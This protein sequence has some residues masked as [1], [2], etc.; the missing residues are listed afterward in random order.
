MTSQ[1][2]LG[3][4]GLIVLAGLGPLAAGSAHAQDDSYLYGGISAGASR[5]KIDQDRIAASLLGAGLA[6]TG[7]QRDERGNAFRVFGGYQFN[8]NIALE[9]GYFDLGKFGFNASTAPAGTLNGQIRLRGLSL[10]L[11][12]A[13][14]LGDRWSL[15]GR[16]GA[17]AAQARDSFS[18]TGAVA[19][20]NPNPSKRE[21]NYKAGAG[22]Q[23][24]FSRNVLMRLEGEHYRVND[25]VGN[26][27]GVNVASL[28]LVFPFGRVAEAAP[29]YVA[30]P[31]Y[32]PPPPP[33]VVPP[34]EPVPVAKAAPVVVMPAPPP[35]PVV[36]VAPVRRRVSFS[37]ESLFG[38]DQSTVKPEGRQA[39]DQ[40]ATDTRG[41]QFDVIS[42]E[43]HTDRLG[44]P[45]YNQRLS[46]RRAEAVKAYLVSTGGFA[47]DKVNVVGKGESSPVT[48]TAACTGSKATPHLIACLQPDRRVDIEVSGSK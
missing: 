42:V 13:L 30:A 40:F 7:F 15:L 10:D 36:V 24:A 43:G 2:L 37:A 29:R 20:L 9:A 44:S 18:G 32:V 27:G 21:L 6:T 26:H 11:V 31:A 39:L 19:V 34:P 38:F 17:Q 25:A 8:R 3:L 1:H 48:E 23:Y 22:L 46:L 47:P 16:V 28:S 5:A 14:P 33:V 41:T 35:L 4:P 12:G 45:D